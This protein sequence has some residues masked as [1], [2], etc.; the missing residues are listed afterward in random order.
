MAM[1][2]F[3]SATVSKVRSA[4]DDVG[5]KVKASQRY[6]CGDSVSAMSLGIGEGHEY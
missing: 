6:G 4:E 3:G 2:S 1:F 5:W